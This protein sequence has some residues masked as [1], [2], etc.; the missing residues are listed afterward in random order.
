[1][2][3]IAALPSGP[4]DGRAV[5]VMP[6]S[7]CEFGYYRPHEFELMLAQIA[8]QDVYGV[9]EATPEVRFPG[10]YV[11]VLTRSRPDDPSLQIATEVTVKDGRIVGVY[12]GCPLTPEELVQQHKLGDPIWAPES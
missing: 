10:D 7:A 3:A 11:L 8:E 2:G 6:F 1:M 9:Y 4:G 5:E 12:S